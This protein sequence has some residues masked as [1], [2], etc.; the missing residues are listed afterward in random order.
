M[1]SKPLLPKTFYTDVDK[2]MKYVIYGDTDSLYINV[3]NLVP[4][5]VEEAMGIANDLAKK[6]NDTIMHVVETQILPAMGIDPQ[7]NYTEFKTEL[8]ADAIMFLSAK[9]SY[10]FRILAREGA[11]IDPPEVRYTGIS[12]KSDI[13]KWSREFI[14]GIVENIALNP[15][16]NP[17]DG[18]NL[19]NQYAIEMKGKL[20]QSI[21]NM[22]FDYV[23]VPKKWGSGYKGD[24][25]WP[26]ISM[27]LFNTITN[28]K[29]LTPM[30][31]AYT[32]PIQLINPTDFE[33]KISGLRHANELT[34]GDVPVAK[35]NYLAFPY[36]YDK[37]HVRK[38]M[39]YFGISIDIQS[40]W[41]K[42]YNKQAS[43]IVKL[44]QATIRQRQHES[45]RG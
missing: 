23:G 19:M 2:P 32:I 15:N 42:I 13:S 9:K 40:V 24:E 37:D 36:K 18:Y 5:S 33:A 17:D 22:D 27:R 30:A 20:D 38:C 7:Y 31:G 34:I 12:V 8:V 44:Q 26:V 39:E 28:S 14:R 1:E 45:V 10:A 21:A 25:P 41:D 43:E 29:V 4:K 3:P 6:I 16:V 35:I 11:I